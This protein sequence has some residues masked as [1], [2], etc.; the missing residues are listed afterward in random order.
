M[1]RFKFNGLEKYEQRLAQMISGATVKNICGQAVYVGAKVVADAVKAEVEAL[2][3]VDHRARGSED[4]PLNGITSV[5][6]QGLID[7]FG[8]SK[9]ACENGYYNVKLGFD[10]YNDVKTKKYPS[11]QPNV[12][13]ARSVN[14]GTSFRAKNQF[15]ARALRKSKS[16]AE[17]AMAEKLEEQLEK[18]WQRSGS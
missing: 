6:K 8:V 18:S 17:K 15:I 16:Q 14:S 2:P 3:V 4:N 5:Q 12:L 9:M 7:G 11:G 1:A 10:G 13:I